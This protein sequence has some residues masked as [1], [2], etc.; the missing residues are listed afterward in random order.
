MRRCRGVPFR[1]RKGREI[2]GEGNV[3]L[4][5]FAPLR[6]FSWLV[7]RRG[8]KAQRLEG[9]GGSIARGLP[10]S[11]AEEGRECFVLRGGDFILGQ[12]VPV[13]FDGGI[14]AVGQK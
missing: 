12:F 2:H 1:P 10:L 3:F 4:C 14:G 7:S 9:G 6:E 5:V 8:A 11:H 13:I